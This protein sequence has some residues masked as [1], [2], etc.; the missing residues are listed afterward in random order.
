MSDI[1]DLLVEQLALGELSDEEAARVRSRLEETGDARLKGLHTS[2]AEILRDYPPE[3]MAA[4]IR[5]RLDALDEPAESKTPWWKWAWAPA[6]AAAA[7]AVVLAVVVDSPEARSLQ[8]WADPADFGQRAGD[9]GDI[10]IK[11]DPAV[12]LKRQRGDRAED[13]RDGSSV[14]A[15]DTLQIS[16]KADGNPHGVIVSIDGASAVTLHFPKSAQHSTAL[17]EGKGVVGG[18]E[19]DD[20]P[21]FERFFFVTSGDPIDVEAVMQAAQ[22]LAASPQADTAALELPAGLDQHPK[23][24]R[25][26]RAR[27]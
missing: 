13:L 9:Y 7:A 15:G 8:Q 14:S 11:G 3:A 2:N 26:R 17:V 25:K 21:S 23:T 10:R 16:Y 19:L 20:A 6:L 1:P 22:T 27:R 4:K 18:F 5:R 12:I 24:L